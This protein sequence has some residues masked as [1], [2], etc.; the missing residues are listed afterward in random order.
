VEDEA[1]YKGSI[2]AG[3]FQVSKSWVFGT[4][5]WLERPA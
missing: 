4:E 1:S 3:Y 2:T 5:A